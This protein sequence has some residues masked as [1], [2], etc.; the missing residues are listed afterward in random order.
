MPKVLIVLP[1]IGTLVMDQYHYNACLIKIPKD[2]APVIVQ[3]PI[4]DLRSEAREAIKDA[5]PP[6]DLNRRYTVKVAGHY[7]GI[8]HASIYK[9]IKE[10]SIKP[11]KDGSRTFIHGSELAKY[12]ARNNGGTSR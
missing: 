11:V 7:L 12:A 1:G 9:R 4:A 10:R 2:Q 6:L 5:L 3:K 8:S